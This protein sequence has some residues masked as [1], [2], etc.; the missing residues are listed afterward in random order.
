M[1][2]ILT[3][4][5]VVDCCEDGREPGLHF[6]WLREGRL[7]VN[8]TIFTLSNR[9]PGFALLEAEAILS[10][11]QRSS[12]IATLGIDRISQTGVMGL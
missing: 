4:S 8:R 5:G 9:G 10:L 1:M 6:L 7:A 3:P 11:Q 12:R 2:S